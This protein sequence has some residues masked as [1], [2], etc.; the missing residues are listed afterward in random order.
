MLDYNALLLSFIINVPRSMLSKIKPHLIEAVASLERDDHSYVYAPNYNEVSFK[1]GQ[2]IANLSNF[3]P[4]EPFRLD[5]ALKHTLL[6]MQ[7]EDPDIHTY[8]FVILERYDPDKESYGLIKNLNTDIKK[9]LG[10][11]FIL[12]NMG[13]ADALKDVCILHP[14]CHYLKIDDIQQMGLQLLHTYHPSEEKGQC[15]QNISSKT[16]TQN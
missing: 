2:A 8:I 1:R 12:C 16:T 14:R 3:L 4:I 6:V 5:I 11:H 7:Q 10:Y 15:D 9:N 13:N